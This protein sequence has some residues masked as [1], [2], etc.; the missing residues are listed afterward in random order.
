MQDK[1]KVTLHCSNNETYVGSI[2]IG[3]DGAYSSV[4]Q[5]MYKELAEAG[6]LPKADSEPLGHGYDCVVG[7]TYPLDPTKY[8]ILKQEFCDFE[9]LLGH[10]IPYTVS[11]PF[12]EKRQVND[13][14]I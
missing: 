1:H 12:R 6:V 3:A 13:A 9:I 14:R 2:L 7:V 8:P 10:K 5:I 4:R 11:D